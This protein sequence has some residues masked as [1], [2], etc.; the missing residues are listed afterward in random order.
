MHPQEER[1]WQTRKTRIDRR[2][3][4]Q[5]WTVVPF[6]AARAISTYKRN[7]IEEFPTDNGPADYVLVSNGR[8]LGVVE[9]KKLSLEPT[10]AEH[11]PEKNSCL[12]SANCRR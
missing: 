9:A 10:A 7:A 12:P 4:A 6:D 5:G 3:E 1:E 11:L 8:I 2:L